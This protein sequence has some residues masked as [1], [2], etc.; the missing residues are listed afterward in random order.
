MRENRRV[1]V[2]FAG[3]A[4]LVLLGCRDG[5]SNKMKGDA[6]LPPVMKDDSDSAKTTAAKQKREVAKAPS[7]DTSSPQK[8]AAAKSKLDKIIDE[9]ANTGV[10]GV[11]DVRTG[12]D[13][14]I[15]K[16][17]IVGAARI[18]T[19]LGAADG[20]QTARSEARLRAAGKFRQFLKEKASIVETV[21]S[22]RIVTLEGKEDSLTESGKKISKNT[23]EYKT[24][25]EGIVRGLQILGYRTVSLNKKEKMYVMVTGWDHKTSEAA[26][27]LAGELDEGDAAEEGNSKEATAEKRKLKDQSGTTRAAKRF[28][29]ED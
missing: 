11:V 16:V 19:I 3:A 14:R 27:K 25:S 24:S 15:T 18:S 21:K 2:W 17:V 4:L 22:E 6:T 7:E 9:Y 1:Q 26:K 5:E 13:G 10:D 28:L 20:L 12:K 8:P 23:E 29:E